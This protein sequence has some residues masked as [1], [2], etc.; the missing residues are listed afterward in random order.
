M[1]VLIALAETFV[2]GDAERRAGWPA[3]ALARTADPAQ[4]RQLR[5][6]LRAMD[7]RAANLALTGEP[8]GVHVDD[9]RRPRALP[10]RLGRVAPRRSG[11]RPSAP[12]AS[13]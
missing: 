2:A 10:P 7:S 1:A 9:A 8:D 4:L 6:V 12:S 5:L 11:G 3:E 13:C